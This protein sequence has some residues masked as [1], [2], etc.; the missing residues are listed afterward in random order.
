MYGINPLVKSE[1]S[2]QR[3]ATRTVKDVEKAT[4]M[5]RPSS[6]GQWCFHD[7]KLS[8]NKYAML[9][10]CKCKKLQK[11][12]K[13]SRIYQRTFKRQPKGLIP[14]TYDV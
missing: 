11:N 2:K 6:Y 12:I 14:G 5:V 4:S 9:H 13:D 10:K 1:L 3:Y 8:I 7:I